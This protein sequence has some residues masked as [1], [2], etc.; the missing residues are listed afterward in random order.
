MIRKKTTWR[1]KKEVEIVKAD[2]KVKKEHVRELSIIDLMDVFYSTEHSKRNVEA[3][4]KEWGLYF[5]S[6]IEI[7]IVTKITLSEN[8]VKSIEKKHTDGVEQMKMFYLIGKA[9]KNK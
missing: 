1:S 9:M 5:E 2:I 8:T 4:K 7:A 6:N 3:L